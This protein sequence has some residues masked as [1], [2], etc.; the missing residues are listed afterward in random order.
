MSR[1]LWSELSTSKPL[2][3]GDVSVRNDAWLIGST[4]DTRYS[5]VINNHMSSVPSFLVDWLHE[6]EIE[7]RG[8]RSARS[9]KATTKQLTAG[10]TQRIPALPGLPAGYQMAP[11]TT[12][13]SARS[14]WLREDLIKMCS[15]SEI[16]ASDQSTSRLLINTAT[17]EWERQVA[18]RMHKLRQM[19]P[20]DLTNRIDNDPDSIFD[21]SAIWDAGQR[22]LEED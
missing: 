4:R 5:H 11:P 17:G 20:F 8:G 10:P 15:L 9:K 3:C 22:L 16:G 7:R 12:E 1:Y 2:R 19:L 14:Y 6:F 13:T 21:N 18:E